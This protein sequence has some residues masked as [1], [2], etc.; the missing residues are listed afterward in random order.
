LDSTHQAYVERIEQFVWVSAYNPR[1]NVE[2]CQKKKCQ[3][4][5]NLH[6]NSSFY[7]TFNANLFL[8]SWMM[9]RMWKKPYTST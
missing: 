8:K 5:Q 7:L 2:N 1:Q 6:N 3:K 9:E 4:C